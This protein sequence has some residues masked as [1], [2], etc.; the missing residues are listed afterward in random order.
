MT[1]SLMKLTKKTV[2]INPIFTGKRGN[3]P[4]VH[5]DRKYLQNKYKFMVYSYE[6]L[7]F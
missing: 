3:I 7:T 4:K 6:K 5:E 2:L 1:L